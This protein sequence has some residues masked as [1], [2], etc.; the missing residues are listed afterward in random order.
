MVNKGGVSARV[1]FIDFDDGRE[2]KYYQE[3][4]RNGKLY[5]QVVT[6]DQF[7][8]MVDITPEFDFMGQPDVQI[9]CTID[10]EK[11]IIWFLSASEVTTLG[12]RD[13]MRRINLFDTE[14]AVTKRT[15][16]SHALSF[17]ELEIDDSIVQSRQAALKDSIKLGSIVVK[18]TRGKANAW[19]PQKMYPRECAK[20]I[21]VASRAVVE[22]Y[23]VTHT[24]KALPLTRRVQP[25]VGWDFVPARGPSGRPQKSRIFY[26]SQEALE[27]L[28]VIPKTIAVKNERKGRQT[29][30][31]DKRAPIRPDLDAEAD[32]KIGDVTPSSRAQEEQMDNEHGGGAAQHP[33]VN[34]NDVAV[35]GTKRKR[36]AAS[37]STS[38]SKKTKR[39]TPA[40][41]PELEQGPP[42]SGT[43]SK[44]RLSAQKVS[45]VVETDAVDQESQAVETAIVD[46]GAHEDGHKGDGVA[47]WLFGKLSSALTTLTQ[48]RAAL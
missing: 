30:T 14:R 31:T 16:M 38:N 36:N 43:R 12:A 15:W 10:G 22:T 20:D 7:I 35:P 28:H 32:I 47:G 2:L 9:R 41:V 27:L 29:N 24:L 1:A 23:H 25:W 18:I 19:G 11:D 5:I 44:A 4:Q 26:R 6:G 37:E 8:V 42:S 17:A 45:K 39:D 13:L 34:S 33:P 48:G 21:R 46:Q 3:H 40:V